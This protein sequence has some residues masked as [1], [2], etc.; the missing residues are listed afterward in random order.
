MSRLK[1]HT[2]HPLLWPN[3]SDEISDTEINGVTIVGAINEMKTVV[4]SLSSIGKYTR[5]LSSL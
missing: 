5:S 3:C 1:K 2:S 4:V